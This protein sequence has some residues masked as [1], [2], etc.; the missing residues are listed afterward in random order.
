MDLIKLQGK[1][2]NSARYMMA[3]SYFLSA[4]NKAIDEYTLAVKY[5]GNLVMSRLRGT[6]TPA[7]LLNLT[8]GTIHI[9]S[10]PSHEFERIR[11]EYEGASDL[12]F[13]DLETSVTADK[14]LKTE[15]CLDNKYA[16]EELIRCKKPVQKVV[17]YLHNDS[18]NSD[19]FTVTSSKPNESWNGT[20]YQESVLANTT[21]NISTNKEEV[22]NDKSFMQNATE[23]LAT[24]SKSVVNDALDVATGMA[25]VEVI[26]Q[27]AFN[28]MPVKVGF[29]GR[30]MGA[31]SWIKDNAFVTLGIVTV[32]H[33]V[34]KSSQGRFAVND[35]VMATADNA[36][37]YATFKA[38]EELPIKKLI[39]DLSE[40]LSKISG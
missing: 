16:L 24:T 37:R 2:E 25:A 40:K 12:Q 20:M 30:L 3:P 34:L 35:Q 26:K 36:L 6:V 22:M 33:T 31:N 39:S 21:A 7:P 23:N 4:V 13:E 10:V 32:V 19:L 15:V 18:L 14:T 1:A 38:V 11:I 29:F 8:F 17:L 28:I 27:I 5:N 9:I